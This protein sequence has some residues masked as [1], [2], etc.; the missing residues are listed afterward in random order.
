M[1]L[2]RLASRIWPQVIWHGG[3]KDGSWLKGYTGSGNSFL[4]PE[5]GCKET[6][7][8]DR[9]RQEK[10]L[11]LTFD[12]GPTRYLTGWILHTL[13][14][15]NACATFFCLGQQVREHPES[16]RSI[17]YAGHAVG[18]HTHN[19][20]SGWHTSSRRY[21]EDIGL[22]SQEIRS[23]LFRPP[24]GRIRPSQVRRLRKAY[25]IVLWDVFSRDCDQRQSPDAILKRLKKQVRPGSIIVFHDS[26]KAEPN[27]RKVLPEFLEYCKEKGYGFGK[28]MS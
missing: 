5:S 24:Y 27:L 28:I 22:A 4:L 10:E 2:Y 7:I 8:I 3:Q 14:K 6:S 9:N 13:A 11:Y 1:N 17:L 21:F 20:L 12:D 25:H 15:H 16:Y 23:N 18:N 19:H 26:E